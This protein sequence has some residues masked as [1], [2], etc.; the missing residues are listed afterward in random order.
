MMQHAGL[1]PFGQAQ[2]WS[3]PAQKWTNAA[4]QPQLG[5]TQ[6][7]IRPGKPHSA[8]WDKVQLKS[9]PAGGC[10]KPAQSG[11]MQRKVAQ[12]P[13]SSRTQPKVGQTKHKFGRTQALL[14]STPN[15]ID[16]RTELVEPKPD[17][18]QNK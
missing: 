11:H 14:G 9:D 5:Q 16:L 1:H 15:N 13:N 10:P 4:L 3:T 8:K 6:S 2:I 7:H 17:L 18:D 12:K